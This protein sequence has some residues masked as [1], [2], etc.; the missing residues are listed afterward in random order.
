MSFLL[1]VVVRILI[2]F[3]ALGCCIASI[4][5]LRCKLIVIV[6]DAERLLA[7]LGLST[8]IHEQIVRDAII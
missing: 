4:R 2:F 3:G 8:I 1:L 6:A 7:T 5:N